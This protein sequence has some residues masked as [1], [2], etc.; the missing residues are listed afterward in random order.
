MAGIAGAA[1]KPWIW[2][3]LAALLEAL[4]TIGHTI[5][6]ASTAPTHGPGEQAVFDAMRSFRFNV[7]GSMRSTWDFYRGYQFSTTVNFVML[8]ALLWL[9]SN[10]GRTAPRQARPMVLTIL[11]AQIFSAILGWTYFFA[12]PGIGGSLIALCLA[13]AVLAMYRGGQSAR[14]TQ[15][16]R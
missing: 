5:T 2:L 3:R 11:G 7:M 6:T 15:A 12:G 16:Q 4:G 9:L 10:L 8:V 1:M 13:M 14:N